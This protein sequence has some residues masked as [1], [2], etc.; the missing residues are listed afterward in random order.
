M[1]A[2]YDN[3]SRQDYPVNAGVSTVGSMELLSYG[4]LYSPNDLF[5]LT[6]AQQKRPE[7]VY[8]IFDGQAQN[9]FYPESMVGISAKAEEKRSG[10]A[11]CGVPV[12]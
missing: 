8:K 9:C 4:G 10:R 12:Q 7:L 3:V 5:M 2:E 1:E 6:S 11:V